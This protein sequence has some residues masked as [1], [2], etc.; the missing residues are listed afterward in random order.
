L[1]CGRRKSGKKNE[2]EPCDDLAAFPL[3]DLAVDVDLG[4]E[5]IQLQAQEEEYW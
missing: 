4:V 5:A 2:L 3:Q 1:T